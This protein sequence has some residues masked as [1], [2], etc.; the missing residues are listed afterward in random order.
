MG[1]VMP[2]IAACLAV[3]VISSTWLVSR[4]GSKAHELDEP[5]EASESIQAALVR[6]ARPRMLEVARVGTIPAFS[7]AV[8]EA[9]TPPSTPSSAQPASRGRSRIYFQSY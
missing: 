9:L 1:P 8:S 3:V 5:H 6:A 7:G 4:L 2:W